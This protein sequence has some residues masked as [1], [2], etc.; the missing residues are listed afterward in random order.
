[1]SGPSKKRFELPNNLAAQLAEKKKKKS[2]PHLFGKPKPAASPERSRWGMDSY[3]SATAASSF[4][5]CDAVLRPPDDTMQGTKRQRPPANSVSAK[6]EGTIIS[7][8]KR[9]QG[10]F[11]AR[12][13]PRGSGGTA[14]EGKDPDVPGPGGATT[15]GKDSG[16]GHGGGDPG[17]QRATEARHDALGATMKKD[18][19][20]ITTTPCGPQRRCALEFALGDHGDPYDEKAVKL[21]LGAPGL[22]VNVMND[23]EETVL[24]VQCSFGRSRTIEL[25]LA[26]PRVDVNQANSDGASPLSTAANLGRDR[27]VELLVADPRMD[28]N[29]VSASTGESPLYI[30]AYMGEDRCVE[31]LLAD[32]RVDVNKVDSAG[33]SPL[34]TAA[35]QGEDSCVELL[36]A[37]PRVDV[38]QT[39]SEGSSPLFTAASLGE[40]RCVELLLADP[41]VDVNQVRTSTGDSPL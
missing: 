39:D 33:E 36:L 41:R 27:C 32:P 7:A 2:E 21:V 16:V 24:L 14:P 38:N 5:S 11:S 31:L 29:Q 3:G 6:G 18:G 23:V 17:E 13:P 10:K 8:A 30:A 22:D 37:D 4:S 9:E 15:E 34:F 12:R 20:D 35:S 19:F 25:L 26:D 40:D 28:V 1:M